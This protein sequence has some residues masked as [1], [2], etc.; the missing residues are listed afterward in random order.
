MSV[1]I[2]D[3]IIRF[4]IRGLVLP[5]IKTTNALPPKAKWMPQ[6]VRTTPGALLKP[7]RIP[8]IG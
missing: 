3:V 5:A 7:M 8:A 2:L 6:T 1:P 4:K